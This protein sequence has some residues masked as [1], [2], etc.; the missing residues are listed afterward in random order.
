MKL[1]YHRDR[2]IWTHRDQ[3]SLTFGGLKNKLSPQTEGDVSQNASFE[4]Q[5]K[6]QHIGPLIGIM[7]SPKNKFSLAGNRSLFTNLQTELLKKQAL[8]FVFSFQ[9]VMKDGWI[10]GYIY[11][12]ENQEWLKAKMPFPDIVYNRIPYRKSEK[13]VPFQ[14]VIKQFNYSSIPIFNPNFLDKWE[15]YK[16]LLDSKLKNILPETILLDSKDSLEAFIKCHKSI[17]IKPR[18]QS[19]GKNTLRLSKENQNYILETHDQN[20][21]IFELEELWSLYGEEFRE[22]IFI[23]QKAIKPAL[24]D[25][26]RYDFR[27]L[28]HWSELKQDYLVTG[29]GIRGADYQ[30]LTT[31]TAYGGSIISYK[32]V[33]T[34]EHDVFIPM[35]VSEIGLVLSK[36]LGFFGEFSIDAGVDMDGNY[37]LFEVNSKPMSFDEKD[38]E[39]NRINQLCHLFIQKT[40]FEA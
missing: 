17:Y 36:K 16:I 8:S 40:G 22:G 19:K 29:I 21:T 26:K 35:I 13:S 20:L 6:D 2:E 18:E 25:G 15:L 28:S 10:I 32:K 27:I 7:T 31:H 14:N 12:P 39:R 34:A 30:R 24:F 33:Q 11:L 5:L 3:S 38:I 4:F 23:A 37:V 9:D 1:Y